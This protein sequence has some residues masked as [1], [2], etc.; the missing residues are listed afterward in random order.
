MAAN[1]GESQSHCPVFFELPMYFFGK[2]GFAE[3]DFLFLALL[4]YLLGTIFLFFLGFL[5]KSKK[6]TRERVSF[7]PPQLSCAQEGPKR[8]ADMAGQ[9]G[10]ERRSARWVRSDLFGWLGTCLVVFW[11]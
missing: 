4:R 8:M 6:T 3:G 10:A 2:P 5:S 11:E 1:A 7:Y 9:A